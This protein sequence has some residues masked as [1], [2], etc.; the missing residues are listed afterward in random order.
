MAR[1]TIDFEYDGKEYSLA[2]TIDIMKRREALFAS[3]INGEKPLSGTEDMFLLAFEANHS[4]V[5]NHIRRAI[6][7][8]FSETSEDGSLMEALLEMAVECREAVK[9]KGNVKWRMNQGN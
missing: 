7:A 8:E 2:Y 4:N 1:T 6:F 3:I 9:P 5:S